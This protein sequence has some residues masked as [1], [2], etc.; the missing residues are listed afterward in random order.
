MFTP[1]VTELVRAG[2]MTAG[3]HERQRRL[4]QASL[5]ARPD[6]PAPHW[7]ERTRTAFSAR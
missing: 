4:V 3:L 1:K 7:D 6:R 5:L 2:Q